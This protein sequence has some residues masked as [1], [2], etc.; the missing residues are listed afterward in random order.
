MRKNNLFTAFAAALL[1]CSVLAMLGAEV[2]QEVTVKEGD[3]LWSVSNY[4]L[5][6]PQSW[7]EILKYNNLPSSDPNIILPGMKLRVPILLIKENLRAAHLIYL[8]NDVRYRRKAAADDWKKAALEM[9]L[10]NDDGLRTL[11]QSKAKV[12][13]FSG[14]ILQLDENSLIILRP[15][16]K[17]EEVNLLSGGVRASRA[18]II[19]NDTRVDPKIE[20]RGPA[21]DFR[22][23]VKEDKTTLVEVYEGIVDVTAQGK[24]V[25][26]TKGF[27][28]EV[29]FKQPPSLQRR[30]PPSPELKVEKASSDIPGTDMKAEAKIINSGSL[31]LDIQAPDANGSFS[32]GKE[33]SKG[34][35]Q[36][37]SSSKVLSQI[38]NKYRIQVS[39]S[40]N[41]NPVIVDETNQLQ[42]K[43]NIDFKKYQ[44]YDGMYYYKISYVDD[45]GFEG[46]SG[47]P[48]RFRIDTT[49]PLIDLNTP[50]D[51]E[52]I[53]S[54]FIHI[55]GKTEP[56]SVLKV[57]DKTVQVGEDGSFVT[58]LTPNSGR[59]LITLISTD[60]AGNITKKELTVDK[61]KAGAAVNKD[62]NINKDQDKTD[63]KSKGLTLLTVGLAVLTAAV[64]LG[65]GILIL[66]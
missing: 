6:N 53:D 50:K 10:Y 14:E 66:K 62:N 58:A 19:A 36:P 56:E 63:K 51:G 39:T 41:F 23:K 65:V 26:L 43:V 8:L 2:L 30:L 27:G 5:K 31:E 44:L 15:E 60:R 32:G 40:Y 13:F 55:E 3:T 17:Q 9:E 25:T 35:S 7:P 37:A 28:T 46:R 20:P 57:N 29:K 52:E 45:M 34:K 1:L 4:Y 42:G 49:P 33:D 47:E 48:Q 12:K 21:P 24:T 61:V 11:Q 16:E 59:N 18:R 22:T 38:I 54:E 64:I